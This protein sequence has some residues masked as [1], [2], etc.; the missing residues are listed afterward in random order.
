MAKSWTIS[1]FMKT[2]PDDDACL[3]HL[4]ETRFGKEPV[5]PKCGQVDT[6]HKL[7][8]LPAYTC[9]CG[10]H[11]HPMAGT[12]FER[13]RTPLKTWFYVMFLF[14][15]TRNGLSAKEIQRQIGVTYKTAWRMGHEIR[16]YMGFVDGDFPIGGPRGKAV[17]IDKTFIGGKD[18]LHRQDKTVVL[19]MV[20]RKGDL[21]TRVLPDRAGET[22]IPHI[23]EWVREGS[24]IMT[25]K[26]PVFQELGWR[27]HY[28]HRTV[29]HAAGEHVR[30][31]V[32]TNT[33][34][35]FW[36]NLKRGI[37][38]TYVWVSRKHLQKYLWEF[39]FRHNLRKEPW[40]M[41]QLL[42]SAFPRGARP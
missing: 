10:H 13:S 27:S 16:K 2:F 5:C 1:Q 40:L 12:P 15:A 8:K 17:E 26:A 25:D 23:A 9:N 29:N 34:E 4:F 41:F 30:G 39:E 36:A 20:E 24:R 18:K 21:V 14:C 22:V 31:G 42:L 35:G 32:H 7:K 19:G 6:F 33:I 11:I 28:V 38:G 37:N 3:A